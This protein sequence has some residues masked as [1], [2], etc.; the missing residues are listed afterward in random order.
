MVGSTR[1]NAVGHRQVGLLMQIRATSVG[2][3]H[4]RYFWVSLSQIS[5]DLCD[6]RLNAHKNTAYVGVMMSSDA[7]GSGRKAATNLG[8]F[9][10]HGFGHMVRPA[11]KYLQHLRATTNLYIPDIV[12]YIVYL[13]VKY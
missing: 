2:V 4:N 7:V 1:L 8:E 3:I 5:P 10:K 9:C 12:I 13:V 6:I 11:L